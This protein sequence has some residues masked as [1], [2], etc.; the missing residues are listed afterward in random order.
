[1][2]ILMTTDT[3]GGV[4]T[5]AVELARGLAPAGV[6]FALATTGSALSA[7]QRRQVDAL[8]NVELHESTYKLEWMSDPWDD[9][10]AAGDWLLGIARAFKPNAVHLNEYSYGRL[11]FDAP[12]LVVGHSCVVSWWEAVKNE[13]APATWDRYRAAVAAGLA[14]ADLVAAPSRA[15]LDRLRELYGPLPKARVIANGRS[16]GPYAPAAE[17]ER[18]ILSA[19]RLWD[20][21]KNIALLGEIAPQLPWPAYVAGGA[22][23]PDGGQ[24]GLPQLRLLGQLDEAEL[25]K[26]YGRAGIY[27]L[28]AKYEPFGLSILEAA[29]SGFAL[30]LGDIPSLREVWGDAAVF[31]PPA[32][33]DAWRHALRRLIDDE[34]FRAQMAERARGRAARYTPERTAASYL[35]TYRQLASQGIRLSECTA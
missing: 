9:V 28:P 27:A 35:S 12:V 23:H 26:W 14:G 19:G 20:E 6:R 22:S 33:P 30:V 32:N 11:P 3:V 1:M 21:A 2:K 31:A 7:G 8:E 13:P 16:A 18:L 5:Y 10:R 24:L 25:A 4:W 17:K 15:M 29:L 34:P